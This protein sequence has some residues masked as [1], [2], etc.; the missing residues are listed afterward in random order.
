MSTT[1]TIL[2]VQV[3]VNAPLEKTWEVFTHP[4]HIIKWNQ[5]S[6]DWHSPWSKNDLREGG[7]FSTRMEA[8]DGSMGFEFGGAYDVVK[9]LEYLAYTLDDGRK[10]TV[11]FTADGNATK[12]AETFEA[13]ETHSPEMQQTGWQAIM[14]SF[15]NYTEAL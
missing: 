6:P 15:K 13:D 1:K 14:D 5:A 9:P 3:L 7:R 2:T 8:K 11:A 10:V 4:D 12:V